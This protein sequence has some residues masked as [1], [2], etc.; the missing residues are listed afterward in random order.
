MEYIVLKDLVK[1]YGSQVA[2]DN[3]SL[4]IARGE[5]FG[6]LGPNGA[7][8]S[9]TIKLL[10]GLL[11][12]DSGRITVSGLDISTNSRQIREMLGLVPQEIAIYQNLTA[13]ENVTFFGSLY[14]L[15]GKKLF[16]YG[17]EA[18]EFVGLADKAATK[19]RTFSGGMKR[20]LNIACAI[21]HKPP[22]IIMDEPTVGI[23]PQSRNHILESVKELNRMGQT[24]IYTSHYMEEVE[25]L[26]GRIAIMD[27]GRI[28][29]CGSKDSLKDPTIS[30]EKVLITA[31]EDV[32]QVVSALEQVPGT[33]Q[34]K[35]VEKSLDITTNRAQDSLQDILFVLAKSGVTIRNIRIQEPNLESLFL[36]LTGKS[37]RD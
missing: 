17:M 8:K 35:V 18:L 6:L 1:R 13:F 7:G 10:V 33:R 34:V 27:N 14:G 5:L 37:L 20:R 9:T 15:R 2:V 23:D 30:G 32:S 4:E 16:R 11:K 19:P 36:E 25:A 31:N 12:P 28:I 22:I 26:C 21:V 29:A 24:I 3:A